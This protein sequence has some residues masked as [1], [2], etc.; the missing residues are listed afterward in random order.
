[1]KRSLVL[2]GALSL[3]A[4]L[5]CASPGVAQSPTIVRGTTVQVTSN[6]TPR[7]DR[8]RPYTFTT[9]GR[10]IPPG[11]YCAPNTNPTPGAGNCVPVICPPGATDIR[12]CLLPGR[13]V[14]CS[15]VVTVRYQKRGTTI[16]SRNVGLRPNCTYRSRVTFRTRLRTRVGNL[17]IRSRYQGNAVLMPRNSSR[18]IVRAG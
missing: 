5:L 3:L 10:V 13:A 2:T 6:T 17:S 1:V 12:Y 15:G 4:A 7:R 14:I 18:K 11:R 9:T 8:T 16:S